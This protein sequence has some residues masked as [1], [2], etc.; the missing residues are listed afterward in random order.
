MHTYR[1]HHRDRSSA[2]VR[3]LSPMEAL[4]AAFVS[5]A[6]G[7]RPLAL[8]AALLTD[9]PEAGPVPVDQVRARLTHPC[10]E[11]GMRERVWSEVVLRA[12]R[13]GEPWTTVVCGLALPGLRRLLARLPRLTRA[14]RPEVEQEMLAAVVAELAVV[15][16]GEALLA[17]RLLAA[18]D[19]AGHRAVYRA[20]TTRHREHRHTLEHGDYAAY[21]G[22]AVDGPGGAPGSEYEVLLRAVDARVISVSEA[23]VIARTR[24]HGVP[25]REVARQWG[26]SRRE[27]F[28]QRA[29]AEDRLGEVLRDRTV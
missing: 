12:R 4:D 24:L 14:D 23:Q 21:T 19:R 2:E 29:A 20:C 17:R 9:H 13:D 3:S 22:Q 6:R 25:L 10:C 11:S 16:P 15:E 18:A 26:V 27:L 28:G 1:N 8:P 5:L 7:I